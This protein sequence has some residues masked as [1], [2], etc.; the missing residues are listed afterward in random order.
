V[1]SL[2]VMPLL[3]RARGRVAARPVS[4]AL[5]ADSRQ[6]FCACPLSAIP[7]GRLWLN[8]L[9]G[10]WWDAPPAALVVVSIIVKER[11]ILP[12]PGRA[13][14]META[15]DAD[16]DSLIHGAARRF[17]WEQFLLTSPGNMHIVCHRNFEITIISRIWSFRNLFRP[18]ICKL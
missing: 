2:I 10:W 8:A 14:M 5:E 12:A 13:V 9:S 16:A 3:A 15:T 18:F 17:D 4:W 11:Q 7:L 6:D 1:L